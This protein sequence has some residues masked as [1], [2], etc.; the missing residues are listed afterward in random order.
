MLE[1]K[2]INAKY[3]KYGKKGE[4]V[5]IIRIFTETNNY[6]AMSREY[7]LIKALKLN[8]LTNEVNGTCYGA[9]RKSWSETE[10]IN[11]GNMMLFNTLKMTIQDPPQLIMEQ[12]V[13][14]PKTTN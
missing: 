12:D 4:G 10:I 9:M 13:M 8:N 14:L 3:A 5:A 6:E 2:K 1:I 7:S 11:F